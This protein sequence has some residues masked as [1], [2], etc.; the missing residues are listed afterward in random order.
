ME[1]T[2]DLWARHIAFRGYLRTHPETAAEYAALKRRLAAE[3]AS[4]R[5]GYT[6]AKTEFIR[7]IEM[8]ALGLSGEIEA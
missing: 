1:T 5:Q 6:E 2:S 4:D 7:S 3:Y 8:K